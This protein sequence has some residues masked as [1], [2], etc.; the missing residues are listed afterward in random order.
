MS[1]TLSS[2]VRLEAAQQE[3]RT[4]PAETPREE[5][6]T[7]WD[8]W[9]LGAAAIATWALL[10][11]SAAI[12]HLTSAPHPLVLALY[13]GAYI[14]G[15]TLSGI[16]AVRDLWRRQVNVDLLMVTAAL[17][18][19][20]VNAWG[21]GAVLLALFSTS[22]AL[23]HAA[24]ERTR[25]AV[26]SLMDLS[27]ETATVIR[28]D[29]ESIVHVSE[30][31]IGDRVLVRPGERVAVDGVVVDGVSEIDQ[32]AITG[33]SVPVKKTRGDT[34]YAATINQQ[35][36]LTVEVTR[37]SQES[38]LAKIIAFVEQAREEKSQTQ[39]FTDRFEGKYAVGVIAASAIVLLI[40]WLGFGRDLG[41]SFYRAM[42]L[43]VVASPCALVISTPASTLSA[44]ANAARNGILFKGGNHLEAAGTIA[45]IAFDKTGTLTTGQQQ[46]TDIV[47]VDERWDERA[48]LT[49]AAGAERLS[50]H[51][52]ADAIVA[53][54]R[55]RGIKLPAPSEFTAVAGKGVVATV[56]GRRIFVGN[57]ALISELGIDPEPAA[58]V[59]RLLREQ[60]KTA[61]MIG[62]A[63]GIR[64]VIAV[65][66][67]LRPEAKAAVDELRQAG[68]KRIVMLTGDNEHVA[69]A[70]GDQLGITDIRADLLP[71]EKLTTI[72]QLMEDGPV[73][74]I[75]D[76][77]NDAPALATATLGVAMGAAG[78]DVALET[79]D[80]VLMSDD[81]RKLP[82]AL[83]LSRRARRTIV[84]NLTFSLSVIVVLVTSALVIGIPLPLGVVG[85]EGSTIL[86]V[87]NGLRLLRT[88][89]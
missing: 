87:L 54:A 79:A 72:R 48:L 17:G 21:E 53:E 38:V 1:V 73:A 44:L 59:L 45:T 85:H 3:Q 80:V 28:N 34:V 15:G 86:V 70:I 13:I 4:N 47:P 29:R 12:D 76:G 84:Q 89:R 56:D 68:V 46:V 62:D 36:A 75:G 6:E 18:A 19:A 82:Y 7:W 5:R 14:T 60:G 37:L 51:H 42:T 8:R 10:L 23:E 20:A 66:D 24:L 31:L 52:L 41:D 65:A 77:V 11:T 49:L 61:V 78:T 32:A 39:Q 88:P 2:P 27:P 57:N 55:E 74:M 83:Q 40:P 69:R 64:G 35:G 26:R 25:R 71:E 58:A 43:L 30:L 63:D 16:Q 22:N 50:E 33:E 9:S 67:A 81:L